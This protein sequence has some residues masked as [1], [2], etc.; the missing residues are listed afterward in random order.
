MLSVPIFGFQKNYLSRLSDS[1]SSLFTLHSEGERGHTKNKIIICYAHFKLTKT[2][3]NIEWI[4]A[5]NKA[6]ICMYMLHV[7]GSNASLVNHLTVFLRNLNIFSFN[8]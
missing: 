2:T 8:F 7:L 3:L 4:L 1:D 5:G 6:A